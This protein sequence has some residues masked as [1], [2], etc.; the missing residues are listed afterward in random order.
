[1]RPYPRRAHDRACPGSPS[2]PTGPLR[3]RRR[4]MA[5][6]IS[7]RTRPLQDHYVRQRHRVPFLQEARVPVSRYLLF[8]QSTPSVG[9]RI[10]RELQ[11]I[12]SDN[13]YPRATRWITLAKESSM[14]SA[15]VSIIDQENDWHFVRPRRLSMAYF[16]LCTWWLNLP[17]FK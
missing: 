13:T 9:T 17:I 4:P 1:M 14:S 3:M 10:Q 5:R 2:S 6:I 16:S 7:R 12:A 15:N 11:W 8:R